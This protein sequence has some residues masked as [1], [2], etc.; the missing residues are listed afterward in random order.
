MKT[1]PDITWAVFPGAYFAHHFIG[2]CMVFERIVSEWQQAEIFSCVRPGSQMSINGL[3][4]TT[5][6]SLQ[7]GETKQKELIG[8]TATS[9]VDMTA[10]SSFYST[11]G[12]LQQQG[13][14]NEE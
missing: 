6:Y 11:G 7:N 9:E 13:N 8:M 1:N 4:Q 12:H 3:L 14:A 2:Y 5:Q 10:L